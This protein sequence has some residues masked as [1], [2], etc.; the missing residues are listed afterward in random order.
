[1]SL[2]DDIPEGALVAL[3]TVAWIYEAACRGGADARR[4]PLRDE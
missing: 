1:M 3:D 2:L 4:G